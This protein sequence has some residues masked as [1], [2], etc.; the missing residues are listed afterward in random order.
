MNCATPRDIRR[1]F[2]PVYRLLRTEHFLLSPETPSGWGGRPRQPPPPPII[3][4]R[5]RLVI[6]IVI[7]W[8]TLQIR[9]HLSN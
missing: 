6:V 1:K 8:F 2:A 5:A 9:R 7:E 3:R 4:H